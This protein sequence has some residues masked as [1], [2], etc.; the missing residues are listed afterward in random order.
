MSAI[1]EMLIN[2]EYTK[3]RQKP[4]LCRYSKHYVIDE[5]TGVFMTLLHEIAEKN[6]SQGEFDGKGCKWNRN[7]I[8]IAKML[9]RWDPSLVYSTTEGEPLER[10]PVELA[11]KN[12]D[13]EMSSLLLEAMSNKCRSEN[14]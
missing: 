9:L 8:P 11:L 5:A 12:Y 6:Q 1:A 10:I 13:D 3:E 2:N 4:H 7:L 14:T